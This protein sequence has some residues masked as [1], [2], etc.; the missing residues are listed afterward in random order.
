VVIIYSFI[1]SFPKTNKQLQAY[2]IIES[3]SCGYYHHHHHH[4]PTI[5][6]FITITIVII[7]II[8]IITIPFTIPITITITIIIAATYCIT[9]VLIC[10]T[11]SIC[12]QMWH[13]VTEF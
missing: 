13:N 2:N 6:I 12:L 4:W 1:H 7:I 8:I 3:Y 5:T 10:C 11:I 9:F